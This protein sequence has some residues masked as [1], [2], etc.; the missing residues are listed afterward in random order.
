MKSGRS[1]WRGWEGVRKRASSRGMTWH[2]NRPK[3]LM[4][5]GQW[6]SQELAST[7]SRWTQKRNVKCIVKTGSG[8]GGADY[9][10]LRRNHIAYHDQAQK[11][12]WI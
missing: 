7:R 11:N 12:L 6:Q 4:R 10:A 9:R 2:I 1:Q 8:Q 5:S 3:W